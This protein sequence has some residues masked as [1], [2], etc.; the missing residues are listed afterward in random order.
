MR[1]GIRQVALVACLGLAGVST[2]WG[3]QSGGVAV[4]PKTQ[5]AIG[6]AP[7]EDVGAPGTDAPDVAALLADRLATKGVERI[8]G[9]ANLGAQ[10]LA[11]PSAEQVV[12]WA[13]RSD[14]GAVV[15]GRTTRLGRSLSIDARVRSGTDGRVVATYVEEAVRAMDLGAAVERLSDQVLE[16]AGQA[17]GGG[18]S[19]RG[20]SSAGNRGAGSGPSAFSKDAPISI[21]ANELEAFEEQGRK[22]FVFTG[23][24]RAVQDDMKLNSDRLEAFYPRNSSQPERLVATGH[25]QMDQ[26]GKRARCQRAT[27]YRA[28]EKVVCTGDAVLYDGEDEVH[29][30][31]I[32]FHLDSEVLHVTG[33]AFVR[34]QS[35][36]EGEGAQ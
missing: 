35:N 34:I 28:D 29:G 33:D 32:T 4:S 16:G 1:V 5:L 19:G 6:V 31:E 21:K 15:V 25:V 2:A 3:Q 18:A 11:E 23:K 17:V 20:G 27:Y 24:V 22:R 13:T 8:V 7:F 14:L 36:E 26:A 30:R 9:P 10:P 12:E